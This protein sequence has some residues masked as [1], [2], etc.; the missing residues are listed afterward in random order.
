MMSKWSRTIA[1]GI[2]ASAVLISGFIGV[3]TTGEPQDKLRHTID[4]V[5]AVLADESL[6]GPERTAERHAKMRRAVTKRFDF[7]EIARRALGTHWRN[8]SPVQQQEF[9]PLFSALLEQSY[10][11]KVDGSD[12]SQ[13]SVRYR[14]EIFDEDGY[15]SVLTDIIRQDDDAE[16]EYR[17]LKRGNDWQIYDVVIEGVS[18]VNNYRTQF[19]KIIREAS[20]EALVKQMKTK[21][22][23]EQALQP[24]KG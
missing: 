1:I 12:G 8:L 4:A 20:Y 19:N 24:S 9:V 13:D 22:A 14:K 5:L 6:Q 10:I 2:I 16:V 23:Q 18:M 17:M 21:L 11:N 3:G 15:A 7:D